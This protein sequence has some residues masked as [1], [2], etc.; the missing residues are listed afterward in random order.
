[1]VLANPTYIYIRFWPTLGTQGCSVRFSGSNGS[2]KFVKVVKPSNCSKGSM[3][4]FGKQALGLLPP[5]S[6]LMFI[7]N[8][9]GKRGPK[10]DHVIILEQ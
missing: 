7:N 4:N 10:W 2:I 6:N 3:C 5:P 9:K 8:Y 1:M